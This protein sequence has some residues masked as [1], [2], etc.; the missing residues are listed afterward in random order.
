MNTNKQLKILLVE[1]SPTDASLLEASIF[2]SGGGE[3]SVTVAGS[4]SQAAEL[5]QHN[6]F[7]AALLDLTL[8]DSSGLETVRLAREHCPD[9]PIVVLTGIDDEQIG[10]ESVRMGVQDYLVK[11]QSDGRSI[12][13]AI[14]YAIERKHAEQ[15][16][17]LA[18][19]RLQY[20]LIETSA[21]IYTAKVSDG[22]GN[23]FVSEN[24]SRM[25]G[26]KA[27]DFIE[28]PNFWLEHIHSDD[29]KEVM[30]SLPAAFK[31][32]YP[33]QR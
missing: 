10:V 1:D 9:L 16:I 32:P 33:L 2:A 23:T 12:I 8:P 3:M 17:L 13:R 18:N 7:N 30:E 29:K 20:L 27:K 26:Y 21:V 4:L 6:H 5:C 19:E 15:Q 11:G 14:R 31:N 22:Y 25:T 24:I 28:N